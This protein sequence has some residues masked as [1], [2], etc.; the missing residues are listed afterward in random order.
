MAK[1][2]GMSQKVELLVMTGL[3]LLVFFL[4]ILA[5]E[6]VLDRWRYADALVGFIKDVAP[7]AIGR[8]RYSDFDQVTA[9]GGAVVAVLLL[10][11]F[12]IFMRLMDVGRFERRQ[13]GLSYW[14]MIKLVSASATLFAIAS[15]FGAGALGV[16]S[17]R[18]ALL[19]FVNRFYAA[20]V[21]AGLLF[22]LPGCLAMVLHIFYAFVVRV[23]EVKKW[24]TK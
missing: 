19:P 14:M 5:T 7:W 6:D 10:P 15:L 17:T 23:F 11:Q 8:A 20:L 3:P 4:S 21:D 24:G 18:M 22:T 2:K 12:L 9:L 13:G 16:P 1:D